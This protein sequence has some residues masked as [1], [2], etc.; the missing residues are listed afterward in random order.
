MSK[1]TFA[2]SN[3]LKVFFAT[4]MRIMIRPNANVATL[5]STKMK[6]EKVCACLVCEESGRIKQEVLSVNNVT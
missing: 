2:A 5:D 1:T 4:M 3:V 6:T